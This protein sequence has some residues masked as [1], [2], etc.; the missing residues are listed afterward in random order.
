MPSPEDLAFSSFLEETKLA[1]S[2]VTSM[3]AF[4]NKGTLFRSIEQERT[5]MQSYLK[6]VKNMMQGCKVHILDLVKRTA[7]A[8][9][10]QS[11]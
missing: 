9:K 4:V 7:P 5:Q 1:P 11:L 6:D 2:L 8:D 10:R 3:S